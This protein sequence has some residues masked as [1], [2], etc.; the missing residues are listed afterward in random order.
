[1]VG[2]VGPNHTSSAIPYFLQGRGGSGDP[3]AGAVGAFDVKKFFLR[4][5]AHCEVRQVKIPHIPSRS[6]GRVSSDAFTKKRK[7]ETNRAA[8]CRLQMSGVVPPLGL[9]VGMAE[10]IA[11]ELVTIAGERRLKLRDSKLSEPLRRDEQAGQQK[12]QRWSGV[13]PHA[14]FFMHNLNGIDANRDTRGVVRCKNGRDI[15]DRD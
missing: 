4:E 1:M 10:A 6:H 7:L 14:L 8:V 13:I 12:R 11:W 15:N 9:I 2:A 5:I 3:G